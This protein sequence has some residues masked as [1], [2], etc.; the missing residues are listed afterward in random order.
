MIS[1]N[2]KSVPTGTPGVY[3]MFDLDGKAAYAGQTSKLRSRLRQHFIRQDSSVVSYGRL[4]IWDI[5]YVDWW[6]TPETDR[7]EQKLLSAYQPYLNFDAEITPPS[8]SVDL[9]IEQPDGTVELVSE[10]ERAFRSEPYNRSKQK[11][12]HLLR[13]VDTIKLAGHSDA[14]KKTLYAHQRIFHENV[15]E[16]L[17]VE[18]E[19][20]H[21]DLSDWVE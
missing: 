21:T 7:A 10:E 9:E 13:M 20:A 6:E 15:S 17:G 14:T 2:L 12:E 8:G 5:A 3:C 1:D 19:E 18:P 11:L 16:F 4:D